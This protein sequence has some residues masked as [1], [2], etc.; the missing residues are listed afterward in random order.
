MPLML[1]TSTLED[2]G[3]LR[4]GP[5]P[6]RQAAF[7]LLELLVVVI[8]LAVLAAVA[9]PMFQRDTEETKL[10]RLDASLSIMREAVERYYYEHRAAYPG[11][12]K[13]DGSGQTLTSAVQAATAFVKQ[14]TLYTDVRGETSA[15]KTATHKYGPYLRT[16]IPE[17]P[18]NNKGGVSCDLINDG[19]VNVVVD[20][21]TG[22]R[23][24]T[25]TGALRAND[26]EH[27]LH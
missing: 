20:G 8:I 23:F 10:V 12:K 11:V 14:M 1:W 7:T 3:G 17:N 18:F 19:L 25:K 4:S 5:P 2:T 24:F 16:G 6:R 13:T 27:K 15:V 26:E 21:T 22:W 9:I